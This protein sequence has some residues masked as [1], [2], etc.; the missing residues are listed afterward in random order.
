[1]TQNQTNEAVD[2]KNTSCD[3]MARFYATKAK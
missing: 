1:M 2:T 3:N